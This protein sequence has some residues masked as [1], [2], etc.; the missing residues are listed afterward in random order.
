MVSLVQNTVSF[1]YIY[2]YMIL[3]LAGE[4]Q[5]YKNL[6]LDTILLSSGVL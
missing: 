4:P 2:I 5:S 3:R 6:I 1:I